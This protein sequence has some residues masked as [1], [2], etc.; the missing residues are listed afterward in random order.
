MY[1]NVISAVHYKQGLLTKSR[2]DKTQG[3]PSTSEVGGTCPPVHPRIYAHGH[4]PCEK[5]DFFIQFCLLDD[6]V[7]AVQSD[8]GDGVFFTR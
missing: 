1:V 6:R 8:F 4:S 7:E 2:G 5:E 3:V